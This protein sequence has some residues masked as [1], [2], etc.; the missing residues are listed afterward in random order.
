ME[1]FPKKEN[2]KEVNITLKEKLLNGEIS[3]GFLKDRLLENDQ[4]DL[5]RTASLKNLEL[6]SQLELVGYVKENP[7]I[8]EEYYRFL[9]FT[10]FHVAQ[11]FIKNNESL[12]YFENALLHA[13]KGKSDEAWVA[14]IEGTLLYLKGQPVPEE[15]ITKTI[16]SGN[17][18]IL[19]N[20]NNGLKERGIPSYLEDYLG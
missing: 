6:L 5:E 16:V 12:S 4:V 13:K 8:I 17:D 9:S 11:N 7:E 2:K 20:F 18:L 15:L 3:F 1:E 14:Y 10:E 19:N